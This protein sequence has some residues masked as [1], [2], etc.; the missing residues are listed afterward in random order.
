[1]FGQPCLQDGDFDRPIRLHRTEANRDS[2]QMRLGGGGGVWMLPR[3]AAKELCGIARLVQLQPQ[4]RRLLGVTEGTV[5]IHRRLGRLDQQIG[6]P[7]PVVIAETLSRFGRQQPHVTAVGRDPQF[8][9][10]FG[11]PAAPRIN[12]PAR[13]HRVQPIGHL[14]GSSQRIRS[15]GGRPSRI[16]D[17]G[18]VQQPMQAGEIHFDRRGGGSRRLAIKTLQC[19]LGRR[20]VVGR[21]QADLESKGWRRKAAP[22]KTPERLEHGACPCA[23]AAPR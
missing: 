6:R 10:R 16:V 2:L 1:M 4:S 17:R 11:L 21:R 15:R 12:T 5:G 3:G 14:G 20:R 8:L 9:E 22:G 13:L 23:V 19:S 7:F 18:P